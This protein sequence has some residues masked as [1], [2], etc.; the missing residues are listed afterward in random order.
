MII[1]FVS[2]KCVVHDTMCCHLLYSFPSN[3]VMYA[4]QNGGDENGALMLTE[5]AKVDLSLT[6]QL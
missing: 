2:T 3:Q 1:L 4:Y 5:G 6:C